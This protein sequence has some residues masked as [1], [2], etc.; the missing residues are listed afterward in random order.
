MNNDADRTENPPS[1]RNDADVDEPVLSKE[2][3]ATDQSPKRSSFE[4][5][6]PQVPAMPS[7]PSAVTDAFS[8]VTDTVS[9]G[10]DV[11][12]DVKDSYGIMIVAGLALAVILFILAYY[13]YVYL[14]QTIIQKIVYEL[15]DSI[16]PRKC[17]VVNRLSGL[18]IPPNVNGN[19]NTF[20]FWIYIND[21]NALAG[22]ELRHVMHIG[23][24]TTLGSSPAVYL[25]GMK[26]RLYIRFAK[27][28]DRT[29]SPSFNGR[30]P[31]DLQ[32]QLTRGLAYNPASDTTP[33]KQLLGETTITNPLDAIKIDLAT[34]GVVV[35]Y[36]PLQRWVHI[37]IVVNETVNRGY[38]ST[39]LDGEIVAQVTSNDKI[40]LSN[41]AQLSV[42]FTSINLAK[43]G[44]VYVGGDIYNNNISRG[45]SGLVSRVAIA[46][47]D[48][49]GAEIKKVFV[50]GPIDGIANALGI[51][52]YAVRNPIYK[53][54]Q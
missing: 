45:F 43:K 51:Q 15:P 53:I 36:V 21:I 26:N 10:A 44:D 37:A 23:D 17:N 12:K 39:Y 24:E 22:D 14:T 6:M 54:D 28:S 5:Y 2:P 33:Y 1:Y 50:K 3:Q 4:S 13:L 25:D 32:E 29:G 20:M 30:G 16:I 48:M 31:T 27:D 52:G 42:D 11:V 41:G 38:I 19:R 9:K 40:A 18:M 46:N 7:I 34:H 35:D 47:F 49:N 8:T